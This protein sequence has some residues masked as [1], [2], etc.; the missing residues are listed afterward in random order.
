MSRGETALDRVFVQ[1][2]ARHTKIKAAFF[3][4][5]KRR[6][7]STRSVLSLAAPSDLDVV[8]DTVF[9]Q[10]RYPFRS[11]PYDATHISRPAPVSNQWDHYLDL[12]PSPTD[13]ETSSL[14]SYEVPD[15][16]EY[17]PEEHMEDVVV[18]LPLKKQSKFRK[19]LRPASYSA[20]APVID[21]AAPPAES[22]Q[23]V[24]HQQP[25]PVAKR[26][27]FFISQ[28]HV[29]G[30]IPQPLKRAD[31]E[32]SQ[33]DVLNSPLI[34]YIRM[35][36]KLS[37]VL[38]PFER[39]IEMFPDHKLLIIALEL[40]IAMWVLYQVSIVIETIALA[41]RALC[42]PLIIVGRVFGYL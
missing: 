25:K 7:S 41:V 34:G 12:Y 4:W 11:V 22:Q 6:G 21:D 40:M 31:T 28:R 29:S 37:V 35:L 18:H 2:E 17:E 42:I 36:S 5:A 20:P 15:G 10:E 30:N 32:A 13:S 26:K 39:L 9:Q 24:V 27:K 23:L 3:P 33:D 8:H 16:S 14:A 1:P 38:E 19:Y